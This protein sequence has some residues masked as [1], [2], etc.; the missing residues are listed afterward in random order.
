VRKSTDVGSFAACKRTSSVSAKRSC[1]LRLLL[2]S[3]QI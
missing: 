2:I 3:G 1:C